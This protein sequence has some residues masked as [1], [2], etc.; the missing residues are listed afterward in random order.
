MERSHAFSLSSRCGRSKTLDLEAIELLAEKFERTQEGRQD[1][2]PGQEEEVWSV[3]RSDFAV[4]WLGRL[5]LYI[6]GSYVSSVARRWANAAKA[7]KSKARP[8]ACQ[9]PIR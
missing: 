3:P 9:V 1:L 6:H 4:E 2:L 8:T 7:F 5:V